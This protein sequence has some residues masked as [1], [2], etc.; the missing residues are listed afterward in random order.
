MAA[1][2]ACSDWALLASEDLASKAATDLPA[3][4]IQTDAAGVPKLHRSFVCKDFQA[5]LDFIAGAGA[6]AERLGHHP[7]LTLTGY[8]NVSITIYTHSLSGCTD[9]DILLAK[10]ID[11]EVKIKYS[12]KF[13]KENPAA[14][15]TA[16]AST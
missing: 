15:P 16:D 10:T 2:K 13:L 9:L 14:A 12:P 5:G 6:I 4:T 11:S 3:W 1:I 8:R 7:D